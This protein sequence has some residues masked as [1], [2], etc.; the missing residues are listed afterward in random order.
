MPKGTHPSAAPTSGRKSTRARARRLDT[1]LTRTSLTRTGHHGRLGPSVRGRTARSQGPVLR[2][3]AAHRPSAAQTG[4][5]REHV[6]RSESGSMQV[7]SMYRYPGGVPGACGG[8]SRFLARSPAVSLQLEDETEERCAEVARPHAG[9]RQPRQICDGLHEW[10]GIPRRQ[11]SLHPVGNQD[12][13]EGSGH[14]G[15][16]NPP[17]SRCH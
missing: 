1:S 7:E 5:E 9:H 17:R 8:A 3:W 11:T 15:L 13:G 10:Q 2:R 12:V 4:Q 6:L 16:S 14:G